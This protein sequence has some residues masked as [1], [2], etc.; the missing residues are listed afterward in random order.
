M[1]S[2]LKE[3]YHVVIIKSLVIGIQEGLEPCKWRHM[4]SVPNCDD[5]S[6]NYGNHYKDTNND[7]DY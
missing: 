6:D 1:A 5:Y 3:S 7:A 2:E 4:I